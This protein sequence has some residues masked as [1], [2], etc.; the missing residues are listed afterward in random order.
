MPAVPR[1]ESQPV[2][3]RSV[4]PLSS[5]VVLTL[6]FIVNVLADLLFIGWLL[7]PRHV[8][9]PGMVGMGDWRLSA[10]RVSFCLVIVVEAIKFVQVA[11]IWILA[12]HAEDPVPL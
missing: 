6:L 1:G 5:R 11:V 9:G 3:F 7:V 10:A 8:P 2:E 12:S 4:L